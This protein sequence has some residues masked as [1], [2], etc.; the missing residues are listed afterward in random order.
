[1]KKTFSIAFI[2]GFFLCGSAI[3]QILDDSTKQLYSAKTV[4]YRLEAEM[5]QNS[6]AKMKDSVLNQFSDKGDFIYQGTKIYQNLGVFGTSARPL[7]FELPGSIG[8]RNGQTSFDYLVP[9][10]SQVQYFNTLSPFTDIQYAQGAKQRAM[11]RTTFAVNVLPRLNIAGQYQRLTALRILNVTQ[12]EERMVDHHSLWLSANYSTKGGKYRVWGYYQHLNHLQ[13]ETGGGKPSRRGLAFTDSLFISPDLNPVY[14]NNNARNRELRNNWY[15]QQVFKP[16]GNAFTIRTSHKRS[17][18]SNRYEDPVPTASF[19]GGETY[20]QKNPTASVSDSLFSLRTFQVWENTGYVGFQDSLQDVNVYIKR[21][22]IQYSNNIQTFNPGSAE[23]ILGFQFHGLYKG[24]R[25]DLVSEWLSP[26]E[27]DLKG[28]ILLKGWN[29]G[30]RLFSY[31]PSVI[32]SEFVSKNLIYETDFKSSRAFQL[33]GSKRFSIGKWS[34]TPSYEQ[35]SVARGIVYDTSFKPQQANKISLN[36]Y[37]GITVEGT[38]ARRF[39]TQNRFIKVLQSG[40]KISGMPGYIFHSS[41]WYDLVKNKKAFGVQ[42]GF[43]LDWRYDWPSENYNPLTGQWYLQNSVTIPPYFLLDAFA[44]IRIDRVRLYFKVH[45]VL[46]KVGSQG[47]FAAP[48]YPAQRRLFEF[49]LNWTFF[50]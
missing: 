11:I 33:T 28:N 24:N 3:G 6:G 5:I 22:D 4:K 39:H 47:Y 31:L 49:G 45:N 25:V 26:N 21:R 20:F 17:R 37:F 10:Q 23:W 15:L 32:Q 9:D 48:L 46:Q 44:N 27:F 8:K 30:G 18:Q 36:Q 16:F 43:N 40:E 35:I 14:L 38:F 2:L 41:H 7:L 12:S 13:Y 1:M 19:Y 34:F 42:L 29:L 50:D